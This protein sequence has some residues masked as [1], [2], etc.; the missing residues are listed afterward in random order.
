MDVVVIDEY[1]EYNEDEFDVLW[2]PE[3]SS[4]ETKQKGF[5]FVPLVNVLNVDSDSVKTNFSSSAAQDYKR[6]F[7]PLLTAGTTETRIELSFLDTFDTLF[8]C[9]I[10]FADF[11]LDMDG[12]QVAYSAIQN[13]ATGRYDAVC[14]L[15]SGVNFLTIIIPNQTPV[16]GLSWFNLGCVT[17]GNRVAI[18]PWYK[19]PQKL[20]EPVHRRTAD[21][22]NEIVKSKGRSFASLN[23]NFRFLEASEMAVMAALD[24]AIDYIGGV[25]VY[26]Y[27]DEKEIILLCA[28]DGA[29]GNSQDTVKYESAGMGL[30]EL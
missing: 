23:L 14:H 17:V 22:Q 10:N 2:W 20:N 9:N 3:Y 27:T 11:I 21:F 6:P 29:L 30:R 28:R 7:Y 25:V 13:V 15:E 16:D 19:I 26:E 18:D 8:L 4:F 12:V 5:Y 24:M 1:A